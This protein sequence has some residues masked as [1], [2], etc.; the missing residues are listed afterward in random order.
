[1]D[2]HAFVFQGITMKLYPNKYHPFPL[3]LEKTESWTD[4]ENQELTVYVKA[5]S[6]SL[7]IQTKRS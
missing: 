5:H 4:A 6:K 3:E 1:M 2:V 7:S